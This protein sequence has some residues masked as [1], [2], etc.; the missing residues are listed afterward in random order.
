MGDLS[1]PFSPDVFDYEVNQLTTLVPITITVSGG[2]AR[3]DG[4]A[5]SKDVP[6]KMQV[7]VLDPSRM[8]AIDGT[9][10]QGMPT[11]YRIHTVPAD[12]PRYTVTTL[13]SPQPG[14]IFVAPNQMRPLDPIDHQVDGQPPFGGIGSPYLYMMNER[15]DLQFYS[16]MNAGVFD[17]KRHLLAD[18]TKRYK[19]VERQRA[20]RIRR[21]C[22]S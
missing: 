14:Q 12:R 5:A 19:L 13:D 6:Y 1:P 11:E 18:G 15:G 21:P 9:D 7:D 3:V 10:A 17:F 8:I 16:R 20:A 4:V 2:D 22:T